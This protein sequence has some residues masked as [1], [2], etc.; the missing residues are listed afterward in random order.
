M[1]TQWRIGMAGCSGLDY[2]PLFRRLD[3]LYEDPAEWQAAYADM[4]VLESAALDAMH[5]K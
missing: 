2:G 3:Q 5:S 1:R 4:R